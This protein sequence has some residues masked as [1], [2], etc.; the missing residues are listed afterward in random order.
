MTKEFAD[1]GLTG[2][3]TQ[4]LPGAAAA[5]AGDAQADAG[6]GELFMLPAEEHA[7][8]LPF[9]AAELAG[10]GKR[11]RGRP[12]GSRNKRSKDVASFLLAMGYRDP[13]E[14]LAAA[15]SADTGAVAEHL[16]ELRRRERARLIEAGHDPAKVHK[17]LP[18]V[19]DPVEV[20]K[21]QLAAARDA[22]PY[23]HARKSPEE[24]PPPNLPLPVM[25]IQNSGPMQVN[26]GDSTVMS[27]GLPPAEISLADQGDSGE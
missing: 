20:W 19:V 23:W 27:A 5:D 15:Y 21:L 1:M 8:P 24:T 16:S 9:D 25:V 7:L 26:V 17:A 22:L 13:M 6:E 11:G 18:A 4:R 14:A 2:A 3:H 12:P 10:D